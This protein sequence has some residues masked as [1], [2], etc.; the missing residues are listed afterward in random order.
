[1]VDRLNE[2][3]IGS[4]PQHLWQGRHAYIVDGTDFRIRAEG[5]VKKEFPP[6]H[7][8]KKEAAW[9]SVKS[10]VATHVV[11]GIALRAVS[12]PMYG[13]KAVSEVGLFPDVI[14]QLPGHSIVLADRGLGT[15]FV[16]F[17]AVKEGHDVLLRLTEE[18]AKQ[19]LGRKIPQKNGESICTWKPGE[20]TQKKY[21]KISIDD[22]ISGRIIKHTVH[23]PGFEP[24]VLFLFTTLTLPVDQIVSL[25][26]L[27]WNI[28]TDFRSMKTA[29]KMELLD[30]RSA[31]MVRKEIALGIAAYNM[32]RHLLA[33]SA[34]QANLQPREVSFKYYASR[35]R[36][37]GIH[38]AAAV[39]LTDEQRETILA[40]LSD[41]LYQIKHPNRPRARPSR[42]RKVLHKPRPFPCWTTSARKM[43]RKKLEVS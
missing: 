11:T 10:V 6:S 20:R 41:R 26:A 2:A 19:A 16:A 33:Y 28:E 12:G 3:I 13:K 42:P 9:S 30:V 22:Q 32:V 1:M 4:H 14:S 40:R 21:P 37:I 7:S 29:L 43:Y 17:T 15:F 39:S 25:Y 36:S 24:K 5:D 38:L 18:R 8:G 27:R 34:H 31:S 23:Q 35:V